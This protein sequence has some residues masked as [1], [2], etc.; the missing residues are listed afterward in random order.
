MESHRPT[1]FAA[2]HLTWRNVATQVSGK[3]HADIRWAEKRYFTCGAQNQYVSYVLIPW[4]LLKAAMWSATVRRSVLANIHAHIWIKGTKN[5]G[6]CLHC[7]HY[8]KKIW[9][10]A[11]IGHLHRCMRTALKPLEPRFKILAGEA[12]TH[13]AHWTREGGGVRHKRERTTVDRSCW[14]CFHT[15]GWECSDVKRS[16]QKGK[17]GKFLKLSTLEAHFSK[18]LCYVAYVILKWNSYFICNTLQRTLIY[19]L[20]TYLQFL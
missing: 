10:Q 20:S 9:L 19:Y 2:N 16:W 17:Q 5:K 7:E 4:W 13:V 11:H 8:L 18:S 3:I 1:A 12:E 6:S 15:A 14:D